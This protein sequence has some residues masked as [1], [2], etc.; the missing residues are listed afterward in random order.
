MPEER[1]YEERDYT[2]PAY[3]D[4][5]KDYE[6][7]YRSLPE[8][9]EI[10]Q[11]CFYENKEMTMENATFRDEVRAHVWSLLESMKSDPSFAKQCVVRDEL[12]GLICDNAAA[13]M[14]SSGTVSKRSEDDDF[15]AQK[16]SWI[17]R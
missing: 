5:W 16:E 13:W 15:S 6:D 1:F 2:D 7:E 9:N 3:D 10:P 8:D 17:A 12:V 11:W 4:G 14:T